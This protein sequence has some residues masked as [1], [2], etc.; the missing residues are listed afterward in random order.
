MLLRGVQLAT[1]HPHFSGPQHQAHE[2]SSWLSRFSIPAMLLSAVLNA[3]TAAPAVSST[4]G[5]HEHTTPCSAILLDQ[6]ARQPC[7][8]C[9]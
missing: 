7:A 5:M 3:V 6:Q 9:E 2:V 4:A 8:S 1:S